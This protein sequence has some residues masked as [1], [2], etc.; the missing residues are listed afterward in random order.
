LKKIE[1]SSFNRFLRV[2]ATVWAKGRTPRPNLPSLLIVMF[3]LADAEM[4]LVLAH[5]FF[6]FDFKLADKESRW[7][8]QYAF[9]LYQKPSLMLHVEVR[10]SL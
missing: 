4:R 8:E 1:S 6:N 3:S 5:L 9:V 10:N 2:R 7:D